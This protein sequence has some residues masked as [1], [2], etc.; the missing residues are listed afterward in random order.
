MRPDGAFKTIHSPKKK[1]CSA[2]VQK[3]STTGFTMNTHLEEGSWVK[4]WDQEDPACTWEH[5]LVRY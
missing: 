2:A 1:I 3:G 5:M 4:E